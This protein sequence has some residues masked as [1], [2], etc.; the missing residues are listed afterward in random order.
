MKIKPLK[1]EH[2]KF[3]GCAEVK[4][5]FKDDAFAKLLDFEQNCV[6]YVKQSKNKDL[7]DLNTSSNNYPLIASNNSNINIE[8][9]TTTYNKGE[10]RVRIEIYANDVRID[11]SNFTTFVNGKKLLA[12]SSVFIEADDGMLIYEIASSLAILTAENY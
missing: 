2:S 6:R 3:Y 12:Q 1:F 7:I 10:R 5:S 9:S 8:F 4:L 11:S